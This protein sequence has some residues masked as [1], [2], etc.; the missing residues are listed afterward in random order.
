[1]LMLPEL[2]V[3]MPT[4]KL[5]PPDEPL[6]DA[7]VAIATLPV[8]LATDDPVSIHTLS[9]CAVPSPL[10]DEIATRPPL[11]NVRPPDSTPSVWTDDIAIAPPLPEPAIP[12]PTETEPLEP[13]SDD[14]D[15]S[16]KLPLDPVR[17]LPVATNTPPVAFGESPDATATLPLASALPLRTVTAPPASTNPAPPEMSRSPPAPLEPT[18]AATFTLPA[19]D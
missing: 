13:K 3:E 7:P 16:C 6:S 10:P 5:M 18:P 4:C 2:L 1:M 12:T 14:P 9:A 19:D 17:A 11:A 8:L 15:N